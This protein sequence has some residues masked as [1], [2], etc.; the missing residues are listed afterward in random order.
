MVIKICDLKININLIYEK[1]FKSINDYI[2]DSKEYD[3]SINSTFNDFNI[4][5]NNIYMETKFFDKYITRNKIIQHQK[6]LDGKY[7]AYIVYDNK[8]ITIYNDKDNTFYDE[9]LLSQYAINYLIDKY[10]NSIFFHSSSIKYNDLGIIF[11]AK[12]GTG[13]STHRRL[14]TKLSNAICINDDK[15]I[16]SLE[17]DILYIN[18]NPWCGKHMVENNIKQELS[19]LV[20][21]YQSKENKVERLSKIKAFKLLLGQIMVPDDSNIDKWNK[22]IDRMLELPIYYY[23]CNM[24]DD[25]FYTLEE[26]I[27]KDYANK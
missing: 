5:L 1:D 23:G 25:A 19:A 12:S 14:W 3:C 27:I 11:S 9:Y 20:F 16:I 21:L 4:E 17:D 24:T 22:I 6:R 18:P 8:N 10:T 15:N 13:K 7:Y 2:I 26:R